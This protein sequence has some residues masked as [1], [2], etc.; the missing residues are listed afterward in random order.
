[1]TATTQT[2]LWV[3]GVAFVGGGDL[4]AA[5]EAFRWMLTQSHWREIRVV[6]TDGVRVLGAWRAE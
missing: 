2:V 5:C 1:M 3:D 6:T 4:W